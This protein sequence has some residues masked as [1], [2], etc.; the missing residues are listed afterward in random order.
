VRR[1][2]IP[3]D[4]RRIEKPAGFFDALNRLTQ[5]SGLPYRALYARF[6]HPDPFVE[7]PFDG[8]VKTA[9][10]YYNQVNNKGLFIIT[11]SK[12]NNEDTYLNS[13]KRQLLEKGYQFKQKADEEIYDI[14]AET[15]QDSYITKFIE[16]L[17]IPFIDLFKQRGFDD[18]QFIE[19]INQNEGILRDQL[20]V[21]RDFYLIYE[22]KLSERNLIDFN[23]MIS[24]AYK[25]IPKLKEKDFGVD[26]KYLII[27]E[28]QDISSQ[29]FNLVER[30]SALF[31]AKIMAVGDDWQSIF[32]YAGARI[33]LF[34]DFNRCLKNAESIAIENTY[35]NSQE[36]IDV[37]G[38][39][40][41]KNEYQ[42]RKKLKSKKHLNNPVELVA[43][44]D[45]NFFEI[46]NNRSKIVDKIIELI[47]N[48]NPKSRILLLGRYARDIYNIQN[49][50][51]FSIKGDKIQSKRN[52][53]AILD[54]LTIHKAKG[55]GYDY[56]I[57][58][59]LS[60]DKYGFPSK[61]ED[62]PIVKL[63]RPKT[64]EIMD[65]AEERR[66][67]Y[68]ALTRTKNKIYMLVPKSKESI[69]AKEIENYKNVKKLYQNTSKQI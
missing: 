24:K 55:L 22:R 63:I 7:L 28:Y 48:K 25:I 39:F 2:E 18:E 58:L 14:L 32:S 30:F 13:L 10:Q 20:I 69:F 3:E 34:K 6:E 43:Y 37:A 60:D 49:E 61:I 36:L 53:T 66:L 16:K 44:N 52:P 23:D 51:L 59:N 1:P 31:N 35:R 67:F 11:Y 57:L 21:L 38:D 50:E 42:I 68:V 19:L 27:D 12:Y 54:F 9:D 65:Y 33:D 29:R 56:C 40:I 26:Y 46:D 47:Y 4:F 17:L 15:S 5:G 62:E 45:D 64:N 41:L 8:R